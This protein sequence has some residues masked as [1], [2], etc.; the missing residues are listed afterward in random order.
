M[1]QSIVVEA[2]LRTTR[3]GPGTGPQRP[4]AGR[5]TEAARLREPAIPCA[6]QR[7]AAGPVVAADRRPDPRG[8][9]AVQVGQQIGVLPR[10]L[11]LVVEAVLGGWLM[12]REGARAWR[13]LRRL[14]GG[15]VPAA[16]WPTPAW[17]WS[18]ASC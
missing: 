15:R 4:W 17:S 18:A 16:S 9:A 11:I 1:S 12:R 6:A 14:R 3:G 13:A 7:L 5:R 8:L 2:L 10:S